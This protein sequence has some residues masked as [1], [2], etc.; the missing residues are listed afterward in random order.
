MKDVRRQP[1]TTM[2]QQVMS[3]LAEWWDRRE[4]IVAGDLPA[5]SLTVTSTLKIESTSKM[6]ASN[7]NYQKLLLA[8]GTSKL[9]L[10]LIPESGCY[11]VSYRS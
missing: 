10:L 7:S 5:S 1:L 11:S 3:T 6:I 8:M 4:L 2:I 9:F